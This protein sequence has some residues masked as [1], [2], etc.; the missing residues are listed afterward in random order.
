MRTTQNTFYT[1]KCNSKFPKHQ[2]CLALGSPAQEDYAEVRRIYRGEAW[3]F[4]RLCLGSAL[5]FLHLLLYASASCAARKA[6][7]Q[8]I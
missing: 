8:C 2:V 5:A 3:H 4:A 6:S 1:L 7:V